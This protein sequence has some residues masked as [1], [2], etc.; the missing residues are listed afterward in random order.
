VVVKNVVSA[1]V[2]DDK[3]ELIVEALELTL[4][5]RN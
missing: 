4:I 3:P 1:V 5:L 2:F